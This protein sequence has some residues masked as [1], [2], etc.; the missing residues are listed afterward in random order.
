[1]GYLA[2]LPNVSILLEKSYQVLEQTFGYT[3]YRGLQ[4]EVIERVLAGQNALAVM[5][6]GTG[7]SLCYQVPALVLPGTALVISPLIALMHDQVS[8]LEQL[9]VPVGSLNS[10]NTI[11]QSQQ[12]W[13]RLQRGELKLLYVAPERAT[14]DHFL[15]RISE[16]PIS[17]FAVDE[18]HCVSQWGHD[19]RPDYLKLARLFDQ[20]PDAPRLALTATADLNSRRDIL[21]KLPLPDGHIF[22]SGFDR[23][24]I[25]YTI[26]VKNQEKKQLLD[27]LE[28]QEQRGKV[29]SG[30]VYCLSRKK[31]E[32]IAEWLCG[33][34]YEALPYHA[35]LS[36]E[37]RALHQRRFQREPNIV[38]V[39][40]IAFGMGIDKPD[41][42]FVVHLD[43]PKSIEAYYQETGRAGRD[44]QP[45]K[46][47]LLYGLQDVITLQQMN[48]QSQAPDQIKRIE[49]QKI[50]SLLGLC[51]S[52]MCRRQILLRYFDSPEVT[53][54]STA[55][56]NCDNCA[57]PPQTF[58]GSESAK[59]ALSVV[60]RTGQRFGAK[61]LTD[62]LLGLKNAR[63]EE[64]GHHKLPTFGVGKKH[65]V[66]E[67][68][69]IFRQL[70]AA[71][72]LSPDPEG[73]GGFRLSAHSKAVLTG[74]Q[75]L[76]LRKDTSRPTPRPAAGSISKKNGQL[77]KN[78]KYWDNLGSTNG[79]DLAPDHDL[80]DKLKSLRKILAKEAGIPP[81][82]IFHDS[83][84]EAMADSQPVTVTELKRIPGVGEAKLIRYGEAFLKVLR[85]H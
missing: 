62:V 69:S 44:G 60:F 30:I 37:Q 1:M 19:F 16:L 63:V 28:T 59:M 34:G 31:V 32:A 73:H 78:A 76:A 56:Q 42:R 83:T 29:P 7:K 68:S 70:L 81:Y 66:E 13:Q 5:P 17:F 22:C 18:A 43:L 23:P 49:S 33:L 55:C 61:H 64:L 2:S 15:E 75:T 39:A 12:T 20:F 80:L 85:E 41:V 47:L 74:Q 26:R 11:S 72:Y 82:F 71:G 52:A 53:A 48:Q 27:F 57:H 45:S 46:A 50:L 58:D 21:E 77:P 79:N 54:L 67:W 25:H 38:M 84:L 10:G 40:T 51:E 24:N 65:G 6:T 9:G 3:A 8:H 14:A 4:R 35:G 36:T